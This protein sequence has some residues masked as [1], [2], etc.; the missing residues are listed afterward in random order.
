[1]NCITWHAEVLQQL[2]HVTCYTLH[3]ASVRSWGPTEG[4][5]SEFCSRIH[6]LDSTQNGLYAHDGSACVADTTIQ[7]FLHEADTSILANRTS[8]AIPSDMTLDKESNPVFSFQM[9]I[10]LRTAS[11]RV[12]PFV[13]SIKHA[14]DGTGNCFSVQHFSVYASL[15]HH[16]AFWLLQMV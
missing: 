5:Q 3:V 12:S 14:A 9:L 1:M 11:K 16:M 8:S 2:K 7:V 6:C 13:T 15:Q 10:S 4:Q